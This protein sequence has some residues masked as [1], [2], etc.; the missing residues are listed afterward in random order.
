MP[1]KTSPP[2]LPI[3]ETVINAI[4]QIEPQL[5]SQGVKSLWL[6]GSVAR[7]D[8]TA[9]SDV[10]NL[11]EIDRDTTFSLVEQAG[12]EIDLEKAI[13]RPTH[14]VL[15][16]SLKSELRQSVLADLIQVF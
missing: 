10:D 4:L 6:F 12:I 11:I 5:K 3:Q 8:A 16:R 7:G 1:K 9:T 15:R 13:G 2:G 14:V